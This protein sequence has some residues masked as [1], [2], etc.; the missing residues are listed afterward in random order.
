MKK[1]KFSKKINK[2]LESLEFIEYTARTLTQILVSIKAGEGTPTLPGMLK[3]G[4][5][6]WGKKYLEYLQ[7]FVNGM[8][9]FERSAFSYVTAGNELRKIRVKL[10]NNELTVKF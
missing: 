9:L 2:Q 5:E 1:M 4:Y 8:E 7:L 10:D 6:A 3:T